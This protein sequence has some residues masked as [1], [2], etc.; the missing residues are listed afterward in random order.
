MR[1]DSA[2]G[3]LTVLDYREHRLRRY[4]AISVMFPIPA[5]AD[6]SHLGA[7]AAGL[8][9]EASTGL[10]LAHAHTICTK[11]DIDLGLFRYLP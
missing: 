11:S 10:G 4:S 2:A 6:Q 9:F 8:D 3:V 5:L 7:F 1:L